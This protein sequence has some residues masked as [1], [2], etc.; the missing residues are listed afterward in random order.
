M[1]VV[2]QKV[3]EAS[4]EIAGKIHNQIGPGLV[5]LLGISTEDGERE[6][7]QMVEKISN[8][9]LFE[10]EGKHFDKSITEEQDLE[11]LLVSQFTLYA[12][13]QKGRRPDF[14]QAAKSDTAKPLYEK[15]IQ[16]L[17]SR[18]IKTKTGIFG[19]DMLVKISN[20]GPITIIIDSSELSSN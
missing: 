6:V 17:E 1:K 3:A 20:D 14:G 16:K 15:F 11:I 19:A 8:L 9:R 2:I 10:S 7:S 13:T 18:N 4:V 5:I 12:S